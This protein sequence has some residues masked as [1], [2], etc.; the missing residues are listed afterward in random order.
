MKITLLFFFVLCSCTNYPGNFKYVIKNNVHYNQD[1]SERHNGEVIMPD[2]LGPFPAVIVVHGG[3]WS[4]RSYEDTTSIA[5]SLA[6]N[7]FV[8]YNINYRYSPEHHHPAQIDD[9]EAAIKF[10][11]TNAKNYKVDTK[12]IGLWG[13]SSGGHTVSYYALTR[14]QNPDLKVGAV[15]AGGVPFDFTWYTRSPYIKGYM[16][17]FRDKMFEQYVDASPSYRITKDSPPF[18][19]YHAEKDTL[20]EHS[21]ATS[22][23][24]RLK[25]YQVPVERCD[26]SWWGHMTV[27]MFSSK[28]LQQGVE[29]LKRKL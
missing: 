12:R 26:V 9:L 2:G 15:V 24:A 5:E 10:L 23:E 28:P 16:G 17:N 6:G 21:Q 29:F 19:I 11:K 13:Y 1:K 8:A 25:M 4:S 18:F 7:G 27:F 22:F 20:V 14:A 3:G